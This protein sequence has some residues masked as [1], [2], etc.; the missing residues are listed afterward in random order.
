VAVIAVSTCAYLDLPLAAA[1][2]RI[3]ALATAAEIRCKG[4][5]G[6]DT[7]AQNRAVSACGLRCSVHAP[8]GIEIWN[9]DPR[10]R[11]AAIM[12]HERLLEACAAAGAEVYVVHPDYSES[13]IVYRLE[14]RAALQASFADL[15][16][17]QRSYPVRIAVENM[18]GRHS[19]HFT[20]PDLDLAGLGLALDV[21]HAQISGTLDA[22]LATAEVAHLHLHD[23]LG[24]GR[25]DLHL[26]LGHGR[27]TPRL[28]ERLLEGHDGLCV[29]EHAREADV[30]ES[31]GFLDRLRLRREVA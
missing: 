14:A 8:E 1:L 13:T 23:N 10:R 16:E 6:I 20:A 11:A 24:I 29:L 19:S 28:V 30:R 17:L 5:H 2:D 12:A 22:F 18:P 3:A 26:P 27:L 4:R 31:L 7:A 21:G 15:Y 9:G 25:P